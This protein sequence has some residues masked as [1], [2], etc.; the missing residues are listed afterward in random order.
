MPQ[1]KIV[2]MLI[3]ETS[4]FTGPDLRPPNRTFQIA[5][6]TLINWPNM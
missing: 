1:L 3:R 5:A 2:A 4:E 6:A